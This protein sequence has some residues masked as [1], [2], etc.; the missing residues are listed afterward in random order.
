MHIFQL[1][2]FLLFLFNSLSHAEQFYNEFYYS[3]CS[4]A[5]YTPNT[6][7]ETNLN[8]LLPILTFNAHFVTFFYTERGG[9][10]N[11]AF[12]L[13]VCR[14]DV[15]FDTCNAC[16]DQATQDI[17]QKC[18]NRREAV[19]WYDICMLRYSDHN[20]QSVYDPSINSLALMRRQQNV[21][22]PR[23][24]NQTLNGLLKNLSSK[25]AFSPSVRMLAMGEA[26]FTASQKIYAVVQCTPDLSRSDC[27]TCLEA[28][29]SEIPVCCDGKDGAVIIGASCAMRY[30]VFPFYAAAPSAFRRPP[31]STTDAAS[32]HG[33]NQ[34]KIIIFTTVA[35]V[36]VLALFSCYV[37]CYRRRR[38]RSPKV[39]EKGHHALLNY[40]G[41][42]VGLELMDSSMNGEETQD[43]PLIDLITIQAATNNFSDENKLG[44]GGFGPVYKGMLSNGKEIAVKRLSRSSGQ[45]PKEFKNE[46]TLIAKLQHRNLVRLLYCC[47]E[48][49]EKLL[50]YEYM[51]NTSLDVFLFNPIKRAQL[52]W[53]RCQKIIG[54]IAKGL[55]YLHED[56]RLR[57]IHRDLKASN[58]LLDH[59]M[60]PKI[61]DFGMARFLGGNQSQINT[62]RVVGTYG[63]M[64]PEYA[65]GGRF[66]V[67]SDVYSFGILL[68][69]IVSGKRNNS[70]HL[71]NHAQSLLTYAWELWCDGTT[72]RLIDPLL[73]QTCQI[74]EVLRWI[75]IGLLCVQQDAADRPT[76]S[77]VVLMLGSESM[78]LPQPTQPG[79][80]VSRV[81]I[82]SDQSSGSAK[83][84][85]M[86]E[87]TIS[88]LQ[89]R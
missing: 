57:I 9:N 70:H 85:S 6:T 56:S 23:R 34:S 24:F 30:E 67:K 39:K 59:E 49:G 19:I 79:F 42:P 83:M 50:I 16:V 10:P 36:L 77:L 48:K 21:S 27:N 33:G 3:N 31:S 25:A 13:F 53:E 38:K 64:A 5:D 20:F 43:L 60:N 58:V 12:G 47:I 46:V 44:E 17:K 18:P 35:S 29:I 74:S 41:P 26:N 45:G 71:P 81:V 8:T 86:N 69:E 55:V 82:E 66:S 68:L 11:S 7:F 61:S 54:G 62:N 87:V 4:V 40:S 52:G 51:P 37:Y 76:M 63:Y 89:P 72:M 78:D 84:G 73:A 65:M 32:G 22:D 14:G 28:A 88:T 80:F 15:S 2:F 75:H 1:S